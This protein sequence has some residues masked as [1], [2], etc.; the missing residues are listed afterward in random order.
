M[1]DR[2]RRDIALFRY[3]LIREAADPDLSAAE[4]GRLVRELA[5]RT[6]R[7]PDG[8]WRSVGRSTLDRWIRDYRA[9]GFDA[10]VPKAAVSRR[11]RAD[12]V[13]AMSGVLGAA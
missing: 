10:L 9:G 8:E 13:A 6:H 1:E 7:G 3:G 11:F 2:R 4:R 5:G 12:Q